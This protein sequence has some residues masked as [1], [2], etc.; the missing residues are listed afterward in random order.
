MDRE[1]WWALVH[2]VTK[3][4]TRLKRLS[5]QVPVALTGCLCEHCLEQQLQKHF[6]N[7][8]QLC[9]PASDNTLKLQVCADPAS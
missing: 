5:T 3:S 8:V 6:V 2:R 1:A 4:R 7:C 9:W